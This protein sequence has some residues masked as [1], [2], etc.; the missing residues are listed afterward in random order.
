MVSAVGLSSDLGF[1]SVFDTG[2][3]VFGCDHFCIYLSTARTRGGPEGPPEERR[4][5]AL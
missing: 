1:P 3:L 4:A 5:S 2:A